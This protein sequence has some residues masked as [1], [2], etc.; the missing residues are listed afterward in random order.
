MTAVN[1]I[2]L[3]HGWGYDSSLWAAVRAH[4]APL[5][6]VSGS[7]PIDVD[8]L[9]FGYFGNAHQPS[10]GAGETLLAVGHSLGALWWLSQAGWPWQRL[11]CINGFPRFTTTAD[12]APA[13]A[14][15]LLARM[16]KQ[17]AANPSAVLADFHA[18]CGASGIWH[19]ALASTLATPATATPVIDTERLVAGLTWLADGDGRA[20]CAARRNDIF[21]LAGANDPIVPPA[22]SAA[23]FA[24]LPAAQI[25][26][27]AT[28]GAASHLLPLT[29]PAHCA[30]WIRRLAT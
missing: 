21:V 15:R 11:L 30:A 5:L 12:Y 25:E 7:V 22:M 3:V 17:F 10:V 24:G 26:Y 16:Q 4:L 9:D 1:R 28:P 20:N 14:P 2:I 29:H 23:A 19:P 18:R 27:I 13:V 6:A 8:T